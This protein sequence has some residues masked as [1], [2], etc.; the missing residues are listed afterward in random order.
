[1]STCGRPFVRLT[2]CVTQGIVFTIVSFGS[3]GLLVMLLWELHVSDSKSTNVF[4]LDTDVFLPRY[5]QNPNQEVS[6]SKVFPAKSS[7]ALRGNYSDFGSVNL[8]AQCW[9][10]HK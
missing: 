3:W 9:S 4:Y 1:M 6:N 5:L 2:L 8:R 7:L 10:A